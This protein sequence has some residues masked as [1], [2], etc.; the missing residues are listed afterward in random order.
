MCV[1]WLMIAFVLQY[2][3]ISRLKEAR[4]QI[5]NKYIGQANKKGNPHEKRTSN[6]PAATLTVYSR[7]YSGLLHD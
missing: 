6:S 1:S 2:V 3:S 7:R 5:P 4:D